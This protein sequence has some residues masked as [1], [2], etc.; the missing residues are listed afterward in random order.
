MLLFFLSL[1]LSRLVAVVQLVVLAVLVPR[2]ILKIKMRK[3]TEVKHLLAMFLLVIHLAPS[4][5][6]LASKVNW[7]CPL[8][9]MCPLLIYYVSIVN[10]NVSIVNSIP[11]PVNV[12]SSGVGDFSF[13]P[14]GIS[15]LKADTSTISSTAG[16]SFP[17]FPAFSPT[18]P[19]STTTGPTT[20]IKTDNFASFPPS[21]TNTG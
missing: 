14:F 5:I 19:P 16:N 1:S 10:Q 6:R 2:H 18:F 17:T 7:Y 9:T 21:S 4:L 12:N 8:S 3:E 13:D 11:L 20:I 15:G